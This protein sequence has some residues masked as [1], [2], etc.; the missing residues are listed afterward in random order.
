M[1]SHPPSINSEC[2]KKKINELRLYGARV[3]PFKVMYPLYSMH[4]ELIVSELEGKKK[5]S[6]MYKIFVNSDIPRLTS[7]FF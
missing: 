3:Y 4:Q 1:Y 6:H 5:S 7:Y 2:I